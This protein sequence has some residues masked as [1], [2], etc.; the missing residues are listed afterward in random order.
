MTIEKHGEKP[1]PDKEQQRRE[2][3]AAA[4]DQD[5]KRHEAKTALYDRLKKPQDG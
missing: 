1:E 5:R 4:L 3:F 2:A